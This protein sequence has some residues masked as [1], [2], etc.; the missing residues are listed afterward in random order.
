[1][2]SVWPGN[3]Y[4]DPANNVVFHTYFNVSHKHGGFDTR[5]TDPGGNDLPHPTQFP[6]SAALFKQLFGPGSR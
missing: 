3:A 4:V 2:E 6:K 5:L 1:L